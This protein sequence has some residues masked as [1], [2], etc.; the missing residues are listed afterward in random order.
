M[1]KIVKM[2]HYRDELVETFQ[3]FRKLGAGWLESL[4]HASSC[5][6]LLA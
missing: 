2:L 3:L 1:T 5:I 4:S 6:I